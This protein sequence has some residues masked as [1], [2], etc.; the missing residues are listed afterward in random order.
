[1]N[2]KFRIIPLPTEIA[3]AARRQAKGGATDH[4]VMVA[5]APTAYPCRHCLRWAQPGERVILF[6]F[7]SIAPGYPYSETGPIFVHEQSCTRYAVADAYPDEF[8][9]GRVLRAYDRRNNM[10]DAVVTNGEEPETMIERLLQ[11]P[12]TEFL[13]ARS[14]SRGC[15]TFKIERA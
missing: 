12:E 14:V 8:R 6:S 3:E 9:M 1:M 13:Q 4:A 2:S 10:I 15:F 11:N 7:E 5:N